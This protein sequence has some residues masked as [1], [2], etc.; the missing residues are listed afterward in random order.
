[1][2]FEQKCLAALK[3]K[4]F[5]GLDN[6]SIKSIRIVNKIAREDD[7]PNL[8]PYIPAADKAIR[9]YSRVMFKANG[10]CSLFE[11]IAG[12]EGKMSEIV[13]K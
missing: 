3:V 5:S 13:N 8:Y 7:Q 9:W 12:L 6:T 11:Y 2:N 4:G 10:P 1:M